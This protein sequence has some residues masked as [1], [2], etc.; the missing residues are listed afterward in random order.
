MKGADT[1]EDVGQTDQTEEILQQKRSEGSSKIDNAD[2]E[3]NQ[4]SD[5][6]KEDSDHDEVEEETYKDAINPDH[7]ERM[8][9]K[10]AGEPIRVRVHDVKIEGNAITKDSVIEAQLERVQN[11]QTT[12][13]LL[14]EVARAN[15]RLESLGIF[16][17]C[18]I[19]LEVGPVELPGTANVIVKVEEAKRPYS[20][21]LGVFSKPET[22]S[23]TFEGSVKWKNLLGYAETWDSTGSYGWDGTTEMSAG[24]HYPRFKGLPVALVTRAS[25]FT[26]DWLKYSSYKERL[27]GLSVGLVSDKHHDLSYNLTWRT[28]ED[29]D[30][31]ASHSVRRQLGH[32]LLSSVKYTFNFDRRDS[33]LRPTRG[34]AFRSATQVAG[35]GPDSKLL[36]FARQEI[37]LRFAIPLGF[38]SAALNIGVSGG[39]IMPWGEGF[40][41]KKTPISD[42]FFMGGHSSL[43]CDMNGPNTILGFRSRGVGPTEI[44][45]AS[46]AVKDGTEAT[47]LRD[48]LGGDLAVTGFA[49]LSFDLPVGYLREQNIHGHCFI[50]AGNLIGLAEEDRRSLSFQ[51][52]LSSFRCSAGAGIVI[53]TRLFRLEV[54]FCQILRQ[55]END[56]GKRGLQLCF[57]SPN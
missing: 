30:R 41:K 7:L 21:D 39:L 50:C 52:F 45:R 11:V 27:V 44:R 9:K 13:E 32:A 19:S 6:E 29:P 12:Q 42:R 8:F 43:V 18:T 1:S 48:T 26:Q 2:V 5:E 38:Y 37:D 16:E 47:Q 34:Y 54:N 15:A 4:D 28:L 25:I 24:L 20:G 35:I 46:A 51:T 53:P 14:Q 22:R 3:Q 33:A 10:F 49:D 57:S 36:R 55:F 56:R 23:W 31:M 40:C 17:K